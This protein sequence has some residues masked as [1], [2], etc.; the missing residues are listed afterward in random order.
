MISVPMISPLVR[1]YPLSSRI[2]FFR[3][4]QRFRVRVADRARVTVFRRETAPSES[5][6]RTGAPVSA[7]NYPRSIDRRVFVI[8][9][10]GL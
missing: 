10:D 9:S 4:D 2:V 7:L 1:G 6:H 3:L 5:L 8:N